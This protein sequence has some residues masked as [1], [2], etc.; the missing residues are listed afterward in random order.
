MSIKFDKLFE[1]MKARGM[2]PHALRRDKIVGNATLEKLKGK[3]VTGGM[4]KH[5][6]GSVDTRAINNICEYM[7]CQPGDIMEFVPG[8]EDYA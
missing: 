3:K 4:G 6:Y 5:Y 2:K 1:L 8:D 7:K